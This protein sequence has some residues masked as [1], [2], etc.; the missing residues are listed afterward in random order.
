[1]PE[2]VKNFKGRVCLPKKL[3]LLLRHQNQVEEEIAAIKL[4]LNISQGLASVTL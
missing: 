2:C 4:K 1:M 3:K